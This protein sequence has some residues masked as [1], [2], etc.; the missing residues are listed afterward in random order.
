MKLVIIVAKDIQN[1]IGKGND[2]PWHL[3]A[4]MRFFKE[5]TIGHIVLMGRKNYESIPERF[6]PLPNR[7]N[8]ILTRDLSYVAEECL[9]LH[10]IND[11]LKWKASQEG[12]NRTLF[13][14]GGGEIFNQ[15]LA[16][17]LVD[18]M[19]IT[20]VETNVEADVFFPEINDAEWHKEI[21]LTHGID[22]K[23][24]YPFT[25]WKYTRLD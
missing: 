10:S 2:L 23:N 16:A 6:R 1:G 21:V 19:F 5:T 18:E 17:N 11:V 13:V 25:I 7:L 20:H 3:P 9:V 8:I 4:D 12:E 15:F 14:I 24:S 22:E